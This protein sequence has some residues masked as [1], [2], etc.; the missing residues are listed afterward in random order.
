MLVDDLAYK[1]KKKKYT[2]VF[3]DKYAD[4]PQWQKQKVLSTRKKESILYAERT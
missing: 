3:S 2:A 4:S 1:N